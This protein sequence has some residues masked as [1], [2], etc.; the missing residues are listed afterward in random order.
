M[1]KCFPLFGKILV[2]ILA[3]GVI[4]SVFLRYVFNISFVWSEE[5]LTMVFVATTFFGAALGMREHEHI[6][7]SHFVDKASPR[8]RRVFVV[9][10][11]III[12]M[13]SLFVIYY[14]LRLIGKVGRIP[15]PAT[16]ISKGVYYS[17]IPISFAIT[18]FYAIINII[19]Q[20]VPH[21]FSHKR[22]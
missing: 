10:S 14:S 11:Q 5:I 1:T 4:I 17:M 16:G 9:S 3:G 13:V 19:G 22:I 20:F 12:I 2:G 8:L 6:A 21:F 15:S 7:I 18:I